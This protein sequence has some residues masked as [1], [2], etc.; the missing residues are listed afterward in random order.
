MAMKKTFLL[1]VLL[2]NLSLQAQTVKLQNIRQTL[3]SFNGAKY[4]GLTAEV[5]ASPDIVEGVLKDK[6]ASQG[7]KPKEIDDFLVFRNV[8]LKSVDSAKLMDAFF[9]VEKKSKKEKDASTV[10][11]IAANH[12]DIPDA[13]LK[14]K[15]AAPIAATAAVSDEILIS[16]NPSLDIKVFEKTLSDKQDE[17]KQHEKKLKDL[18]DDSVKYVKKQIDLEDDILKNKKEQEKVRGDLDKASKN[19][20]DTK[21]IVKKLDDLVDDQVKYEKK[22]RSLFD[23]MGQNKKEQEIERANLA[24]LGKE[25]ENIKAQRPG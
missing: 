19:V 12:G 16:L 21:K 5:Q 11:F 7:V 22:L 9:R 4:N 8:I 17:I 13:K 1:F 15:S 6:F 23:T 25:L 18:Y 24:R 3:V 10:S 14:S 20:G 2:A